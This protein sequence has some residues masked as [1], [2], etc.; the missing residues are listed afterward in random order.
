MLFGTMTHGG[1]INFDVGLVSNSLLLETYLSKQSEDI[2]FPC[3]V[4]FLCSSVG[5]VGSLA[6]DERSSA[7]SVEGIR[8]NVE[9]PVV[10]LVVTV[11]EA[12]SQVS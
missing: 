12:E 2:I 4:V 11:A 5:I 8:N 3:L 7:S 9:D 10:V 1:E 6:W